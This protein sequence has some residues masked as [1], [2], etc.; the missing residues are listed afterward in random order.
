[1]GIVFA[2]KVLMFCTLFDSNLA[3]IFNLETNLPSPSTT[4]P[5]CVYPPPVCIASDLIRYCIQHVHVCQLFQVDR[6]R[7]NYRHN[8][9]DILDHVVRESSVIGIQGVR[10]RFFFLFNVH[11]SILNNQYGKCISVVVSNLFRPH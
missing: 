1:M 8:A 2:F 5:M 4:P 11:G 6:S 7:Q 10:S 9:Q 3:S